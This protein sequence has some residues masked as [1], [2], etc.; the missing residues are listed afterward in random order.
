MHNTLLNV[1]KAGSSGNCQRQ[2]RAGD[3]ARHYPLRRDVISV[4]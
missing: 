2:L 3:H 4:W 1:V